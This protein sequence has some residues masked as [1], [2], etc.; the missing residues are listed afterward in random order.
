M[1][2][3]DSLGVVFYSPSMVT[4]AISSAVSIISIDI[5]IVILHHID[6]DSPNMKSVDLAARPSY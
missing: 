5:D 1:V 3:F 2:P 6:I 4:M